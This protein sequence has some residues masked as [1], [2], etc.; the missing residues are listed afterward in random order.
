MEHRNEEKPATAATVNGFQNDP[1]WTAIENEIIIPPTADQ[2]AAK[3]LCRR[4]GVP[5][6]LAP[7]LAALAGLGDRRAA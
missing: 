6:A 2:Q 4:F 1:L 7:V 3:M 5:P